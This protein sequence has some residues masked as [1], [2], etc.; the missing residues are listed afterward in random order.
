MSETREDVPQPISP[1]ELML[2][3]TAVNL[4]DKY[5]AGITNRDE[6]R[7][8]ILLYLSVINTAARFLPRQEADSPTGKKA[9]I[10]ETSEAIRQS[11]INNWE[12]AKNVATHY[13]RVMMEG[14]AEG[15]PDS[16]FAEHSAIAMSN[17]IRSLAL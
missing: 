7:A 12:P 2:F 1:L 8:D 13:I 3:N 15:H 4:T 9:T 5:A 11:T 16:D 10:E 14:A 17:L 6:A